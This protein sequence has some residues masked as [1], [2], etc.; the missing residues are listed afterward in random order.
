MVSI[1][2]LV[3]EFAMYIYYTV[4]TYGIMEY[5]VVWKIVIILLMIICANSISSMVHECGHLIGGLLSKHKLLSI[6]LGFLKLSRNKGN[7]YLG[8]SR[9]NNQCIMIPNKEAPAFMLYQMGGVLLNFIFAL[10]LSY[11]GYFYLVHGSL[12]FLFVCA[13]ITTG[14]CKISS[15]GIPIYKNTYPLNDMAYEKILEKDRATREEYYLYLRCLEAVSNDE[16]INEINRPY[17]TSGKDYCDLF[18][19]KILELQDGCKG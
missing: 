9:W 2:I 1:I 7:I 12:I 15:N 5:L 10:A 16:D 14:I 8:F 4:V 11:V 13:L 17:S 19:K 18:W 3:F 6:Q